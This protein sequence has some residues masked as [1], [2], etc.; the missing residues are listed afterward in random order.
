MN[1]ENVPSAKHY[2]NEEVLDE[3][4]EILTIQSKRIGKWKLTKLLSSLK[5]KK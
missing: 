4:N 1:E 5:K 2:G 3:D